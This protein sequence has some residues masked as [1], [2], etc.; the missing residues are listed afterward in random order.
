MKCPLWRCTADPDRVVCPACAGRSIPMSTRS[1][2]STSAAAG[3]APRMPAIPRSIWAPTPPITSSPTSK[4][5]AGTWG[6]TTG[7][8]GMVLG[9]HTGTGLRPGAPPTGKGD[10]PGGG[11]HHQRQRRRVGHARRRQAVSRSVGAVSRRAARR[12]AG[13][14][15][16]RWLCP[17]AF[18]PG[19][20]CPRQGRPRLVRL[21]GKP[22]QYARQSP[23]RRPTV[24]NVLR[25]LGNVTIGVMRP[26]AR[27]ANC[28][29]ASTALRISRPSWS[30]AG[31]T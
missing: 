6:S 15:H 23:L 11:H 5:S 12:P 22:R 14:Q 17:P 1:F 21:G 19:S 13:R 28:W 8:R 30:T 18:Q 31:W 2:C 20:A 16:R 26:G 29:P 9:H 3:E 10:G 7:D 24:P 27:R 4:P 25:A